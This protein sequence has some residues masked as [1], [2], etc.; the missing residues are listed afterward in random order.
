MDEFD[1]YE[2]DLFSDVEQNYD[3]ELAALENENAQMAQIDREFEE[4]RQAA[5]EVDEEVISK[6]DN[7]AT[8][9]TTPFNI[10]DETTDDVSAQEDTAS[11]TPVVTVAETEQPIQ[12]QQ[13][14]QQPTPSEQL[15]AQQQVQQPT[16][17]P[18]QQQPAQTNVQ[19]QQM[20]NPHRAS[21]N[22]KKPVEEKPPIPTYNPVQNVQQQSNN[23]TVA[24]QGAYHQGQTYDESVSPQ[25]QPQPVKEP[26]KMDPTTTATKEEMEMV[27][28]VSKKIAVFF[29]ALL[30]IVGIPVILFNAM[31]KKTKKPEQQPQTTV[32]SV[33]DTQNT[34]TATTE[35]DF[36]D[37]FADDWLTVPDITEPPTEAPTTATPTTEAATEAQSRFE[38]LEELTVY[39]E[40]NQGL[41]LSNM[42]MAVLD[43]E[44][45]HISH[46][47]YINKMNTLIAAANELNNLLILNADEYAAQG[48][49]DTY[50]TLVQNM[51]NVIVY[52]ANAITK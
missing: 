4:S 13:P 29:I 46:D 14:V 20:V 50:N 2:D 27:K 3:E 40:S 48:Q 23:M 37:P 1:S 10:P 8:A 24:S 39:V 5:Q 41:I 18:V 51:N 38:T 30:L 9:E 34:Q 42:Q 36:Y 6:N 15:S 31:G 17:Q 32:S 44:Q 16:Q 43:Y 22:Q 47:E 35:A 28:N 19:T 33:P 49:Q 11:E 12:Q 7:V 25:P 21:M 45:G 26:P 52:G